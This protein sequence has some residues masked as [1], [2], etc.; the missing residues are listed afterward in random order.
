VVDEVGT[1]VDV[2]EVVCVVVV[3]QVALVED[4]VDVAVEQ[5]TVPQ[6]PV[7]QAAFVVEVIHEAVSLEQPPSAIESTAP[8]QRSEERIKASC[9][10]IARSYLASFDRQTGDARMT[11]RR[12]RRMRRGGRHEVGGVV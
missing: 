4:V 1:T 2:A 10:S 5:A 8:P 7:P 3:A 12:A 11:R 9:R 6:F